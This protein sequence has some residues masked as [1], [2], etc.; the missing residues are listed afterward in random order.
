MTRV[1]VLAVLYFL[2]GLLGR[3]AWFAFGNA[4]YALVWPALGLAMTTGLWLGNRY[5]PGMAVG[6]LLMTLIAR[7]PF[8]FLTLGAVLGSTLGAVTGTF[9]LNRVFGFK[10]GLERM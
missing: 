7:V 8:G 5:W 6:A 4:G 9:L 2:A 10:H 3:E 1:G